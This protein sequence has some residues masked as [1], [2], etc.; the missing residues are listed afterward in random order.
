MFIR[1]WLWY[2]NMVITTKVMFP[3]APHFKSPPW[4][5]AS[6]GPYVLEWPWWSLAAVANQQQTSLPRRFA[7]SQGYELQWYIQKNTFKNSW[8]KK[9]VVN[10][11]TN[12]M[13]SNQNWSTYWFVQY[14][15]RYYHAPRKINM[16]P[17][18][19]PIEIRK[20]IIQT[21]IF[22]FH[23]NLPGCDITYYHH[24]IYTIK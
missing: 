14:C 20:I 22:R 5:V 3:H 24:Y 18:N 12:V 16:E 11:Y 9:Q 21:I 10:K 2:S 6:L 4:T 17:N 15:I 23:V 19:H 1:P 13:S 7:I 8:E